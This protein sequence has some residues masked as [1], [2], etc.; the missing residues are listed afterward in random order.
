MHFSCF[1]SFGQ[2][3]SLDFGHPHS[4]R[5]LLC[6]C[7]FLDFF[8]PAGL[9]LSILRIRIPTVNTFADAL[10]LVWFLPPVQRAA[11]HTCVHGN[12]NRARTA[13][14]SSPFH[15]ISPTRLR[16]LHSRRVTGIRIPC[17]TTP[18]SYLLS[19]HEKEQLCT[20]VCSCSFS[21]TGLIT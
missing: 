9:R 1:A 14:A 4:A 15:V 6:G 8:P 11:L 16:A 19:S 13:S 21:E 12:R 7:T 2:S 20:H 10:F 5:E 3:R 17:L 18:C